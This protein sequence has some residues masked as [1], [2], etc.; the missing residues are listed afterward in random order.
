[1]KIL[2]ISEARRKVVSAVIFTLV[3]AGTLYKYTG[4]GLVAAMVLK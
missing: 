3:R 2:S 4:T 1:M